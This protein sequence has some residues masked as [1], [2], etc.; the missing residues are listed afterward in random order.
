LPV[1]SRYIES[2]P[3]TVLRVPDPSMAD[4]ARWVLESS[5]ATVSIAE[6]NGPR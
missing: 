2:A 5:G 4:A 6:L 3:V 1:I